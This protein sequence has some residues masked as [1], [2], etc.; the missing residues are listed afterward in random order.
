MIMS[1]TYRKKN[2]KPVFPFRVATLMKNAS[3]VQL[4]YRGSNVLPQLNQN[5]NSGNH[6]SKQLAKSQSQKIPFMQH[7]SS[8][9]KH[10]KNSGPSK[11]NKQNQSLQESLKV[12]Y[13]AKENLELMRR[14]VNAKKGVDFK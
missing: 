13:L 8:T 4:A 1:A 2:L 12:K 11:S 3:G 6:K 9:P 7:S 10:I 14:L 5:A